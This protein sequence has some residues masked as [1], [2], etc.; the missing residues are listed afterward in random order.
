MHEMGG[1]MRYLASLFFFTISISAAAEPRIAEVEVVNEPS[2]Y[3]TND[4]GVEVVNQE[5]ILVENVNPPTPGTTRTVLRDATGELVGEIPVGLEAFV[6][7]GGSLVL[8]DVGGTTVPVRATQLKLSGWGSFSIN[9]VDGNYT[10]TDCSDDPLGKQP[11]L[12]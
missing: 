8:I 9:T 12:A 5:P 1:C 10:T 6:A 11:G 3:V 7:A 2:V 4:V